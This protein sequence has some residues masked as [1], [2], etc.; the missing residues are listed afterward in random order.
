MKGCDRE[1]YS[2]GLWQDSQVSLIAF[3]SNGT[4]HPDAFIAINL[5]DKTHALPI[6][7]LGTGASAFEAF[8]TSPDGRYAPL[9][10]FKVQAGFVAYE[11]PARSV[12]TFYAA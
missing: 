7:I 1:V 11:A 10:K 6:Q 9:G 2:G 3:A 12:T 8:R 4:R 5:D